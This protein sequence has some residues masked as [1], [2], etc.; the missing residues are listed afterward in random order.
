LVGLLVFI[1]MQLSGV[2]IVDIVLESE[3]SD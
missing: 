2:F 1:V 3:S